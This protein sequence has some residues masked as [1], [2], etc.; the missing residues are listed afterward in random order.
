MTYE[1][2]TL[3]KEQDVSADA[4]VVFRTVNVQ[5]E[6]RDRNENV[7]DINDAKLE[8]QQESWR[9]FG[10][11]SGGRAS[12]ELL[13]ETYLFRLYYGDKK[14]QQKQNVGDNPLVIFYV[15]GPTAEP[16]ATDT[17]EPTARMHP[18]IHRSRQRPRSRP[19]R[20]DQRRRRRRPTHPSR[21]QPPSLPLRR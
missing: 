9:D 19:T 11:T 13:P 7:L 2:T 15:E 6:L 18:R 14:D 4:V 1:H 5:V 3:E 17:L 20:L 12:R 21:Q 16:T 8:W 10:V